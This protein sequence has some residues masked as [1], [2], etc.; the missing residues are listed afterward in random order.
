M[1]LPR[2]P[3]RGALGPA[4][5]RAERLLRARVRDGIHRLLENEPADMPAASREAQ[6]RQLIQQ[7]LAEYDRQAVLTRGATL[8]EPAK[9]ET[10]LVNAFLKYGPITELLE[11]AR[12]EEVQVNGASAV[13]AVLDGRLWLV[14]DAAYDTDDEP[15]AI[16]KRLLEPQGIRLDQA[17]PLADARVPG[18]GRVN[19][20]IPPASPDGVYLSIR[21]YVLTVHSL[22]ELIQWRAVTEEAAHFLE[23]CVRAH[24]TIV[25]SGRTGVGKTSWVNCLAN[26]VPEHERICTIEEDRELQLTV[27]NRVPL[28]GRPAN[29]EGVGGITLRQL[30][31]DSLRK[32]PSR[33][34]VGEV[35]GEESF[36]LLSALTS[37]HPGS[38]TTIHGGSPEDALDRL[39]VF[40]QLASERLT[41]VMV[42]RMIRRSVQ[43]VL[44]LGEQ[45]DADGYKSRYL[46]AIWELTGL[47]VAA[48]TATLL[49][50]DLWRREQG[51]LR[52]QRRVPQFLAQFAEYGVSYTLPPL[53]GE[54]SA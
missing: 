27:P 29:I 34:I 44:Q 14:P 35:R 54:R 39:A 2:Y 19:V 12:C 4:D 49:G 17:S 48:G 30:V 52:W 50:H 53:E 1:A 25:I 20:S 6:V 41:T 36:E 33:I 5:R 21:R 31:R 3:L 18:V 9:V 46:Q 16:A 47:D 40:A 24:I 13:F 11:D 7:T 10:W 23:A 42:L 45:E 28:V 43:L 8:V 32:R 15:L 37:G 51:Q 38:F 26:T 22:A